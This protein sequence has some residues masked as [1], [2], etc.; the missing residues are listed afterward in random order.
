MLGIEQYALGHVF[1]GSQDHSRI[2]RLSYDDPAYAALTPH[3]YIAWEHVEAESG[4][5]LVHRTGGLVFGPAPQNNEVTEVQRYAAAMQ[6]IGVPYDA[7]TP[8]EAMGRFPQFH[9]HGD[10]EVLYQ[11]SSGLV[12]AAKANATHRT[13]ALAHGAAL[14]S[15]TPVLSVQPFDEGVEVTTSA[16]TF[17]AHRLILAAGAWSNQVLKDFGVQLDLRVTEEQVT[18][19]ATPHLRKFAPDRFPVWIWHGEANFYG[20]PVYGEVGTKAGEHIGGD[21]V[22]VETRRLAPNPR[23]LENLQ[24][25]LGERIPDFLGPIL[26]TKPCLYTMPPDLGFILD[27]LPEHPQ[28]AV[29]VGAGHAFKFASLHGRILSDISLDGGTPFDITAF[30]LQRPGVLAGVATR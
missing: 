27:R 9:L 7:L 10:D 19:F 13:L 1:G 28:V 16:G 11:A 8:V 30:T 17:Y 4:V 25:F 2:I 23:P 26:Y 5:K 6:R 21:T 24:R 15:E 18:Y 22:T 3:T 12:D 29:F 20:F 14:L